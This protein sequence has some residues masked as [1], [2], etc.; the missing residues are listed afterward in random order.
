MSKQ[1]DLQYKKALLLI[2]IEQQR[3]DLAHSTRD[4]LAH[5]AP[6]DNSYR[7]LF[8][9]RKPVF[10]G[11]TIIGLIAMRKPAKTAQLSRTAG[12]VWAT[13]RMVQRLMNTL[14]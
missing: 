8:E 5:T 3:L 9:M 10:I 1:K 7:I 2:K 12:K 6:I 11:A 14:S 13:T 4:F